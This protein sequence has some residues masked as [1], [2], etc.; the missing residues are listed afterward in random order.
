MKRNLMFFSLMLFSSLFAADLSPREIIQRCIK[1][2]GGQQNFDKIKNLY[3]KMD[4]HSKNEKADVESLIEQYFRF[5]NK[6]RAEISS[7]MNPPT[8]VSWNG[9]EAWQLTKNKL[10]KTKDPRQRDNLKESLRFVK[11]IMLTNL[12]EKDSTLKYEKHVKRKTYGIHVVSQTNKQGEDIK[13][14][15]KDSDYSLFGGEFSWQG[16]N[17]IFKVFLD[18][19]NYWVDGI[20]FPREARI[21]R[22][23]E[24][25]L[26]AKVR[27]IKINHLKNGNS[28]FTNLKEKPK[29]KKRGRTRRGRGGNKRTRQP[30]QYKKD[31]ENKKNNEDD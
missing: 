14:Y 17:T 13:I 31:D 24:K 1:R 9:K 19:Q 4:V 10:E 15:I 23:N 12:L 3:V 28:F 5:P 18:K 8:K 21:Y 6:L 27:Q 22:G 25:V 11:L 16:N 7:M 30:R 26:D 29:M 20:C 2:H